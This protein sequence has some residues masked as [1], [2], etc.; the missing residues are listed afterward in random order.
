VKFYLDNPE[1]K[2]KP[3]AAE[4]WLLLRA[5][6][7]EPLMRIY[8]ESC[9]K[10]SV[11]KLL[12]W[13]VSEITDNVLVHSRSPIGGL[14][15][16]ST[17]QRANKRIEYIVADAGVGIPGTLRPSHPELT[18]DA[19]ALERAIREGVTRDSDVGQG[20]GLYGSYQICSHSIGSFH[21]ESGYGKLTFT[22]RQGLRVTTERVPFNGTLVVAQINFSDP[23]L[24]AEALRF[25]G[26]QHIPVDFVETNYEQHD[27]RSVSSTQYFHIS[28]SEMLI[29]LPYISP[30]AR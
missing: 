17:F 23:R 25:G 9:S 1:A 15:Q 18:S 8:T 3:N 2:T 29:S 30:P 12:E 7:T 11:A 20:N 13:S 27:L 14:I 4:T 28:S 6:G 21:L 24:L 22:E 19:A 26:R 10:E 5:S 16:V